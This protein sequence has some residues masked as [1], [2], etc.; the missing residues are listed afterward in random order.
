MK[1]DIT[2]ELFQAIK[3]F[4]HEI[5]ISRF[6]LQRLSKLI[7]LVFLK[8]LS[9]SLSIILIIHYLELLKSRNYKFCQKTLLDAFML[10]CII[11]ADIKF[12]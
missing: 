9:L 11:V 1:K 8:S 10:R 2:P 3:L 7:S 12:H 6:L 4:M 5:L